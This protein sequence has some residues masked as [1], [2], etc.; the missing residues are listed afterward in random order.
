MTQRLPAMMHLLLTDDVMISPAD[1]MVVCF[2]GAMPENMGILNLY[3]MMGCL[4]MRAQHDLAN[5]AL[6][7]IILEKDGAVLEI[8]NNM[9]LVYDVIG[10]VISE[11]DDAV[12]EVN[13][14]MHD[15]EADR[16]A[17]ADVPV[18]KVT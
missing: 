18:E 15:V 12:L 8:G 9:L 6:D 16:L 3:L 17:P 11:N 7:G 5:A 2:D 1:K 14:T 4:A 13:D 10:D